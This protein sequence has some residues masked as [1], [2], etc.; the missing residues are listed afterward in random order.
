MKK[1]EY[2]RL[3]MDFFDLAELNRFG[4]DGWRVVSVISDVQ[5]N[6]AILEREINGVSEL[7]NRW[8]PECSRAYKTVSQQTVCPVCEKDVLQ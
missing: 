7:T 2:V 4:S 6:V 5:F 8:C 1:F 3:L